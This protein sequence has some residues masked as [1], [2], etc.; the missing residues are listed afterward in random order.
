LIIMREFVL[1]GKFYIT[2][3]PTVLETL[4]GSCVSVCLYNHKHGIGAMNHF[5]RDRPTGEDVG[6]IGEFG[7]TSTRH[8]IDKLMAIDNVSTHYTAMVYGG[9][10]VVKTTG[11]ESDIGRKNVETALDI[12]ADACICVT[13]KQVFGTRG[14]RVKFNT[15]DGSVMCRFAGDIPGKSG[16]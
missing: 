15:M 12:L 14:R 4:V 8:I 10:A 5:L 1:P 13:E 11:R 3:R 16:G 6:N 9:A 7:S 2:T